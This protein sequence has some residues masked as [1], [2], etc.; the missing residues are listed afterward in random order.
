[1]RKY[2]LL[3]VLL[4]SCAFIITNCT[5]EGPEGPPGPAGAQG[6][7]GPPGP[8]GPAGAV[9]SANVIYSNW[10]SAASQGGFRDTTW[11]A[12]QGRTFHKVVTGLT[13]AMLDGGVVLSYW[14]PAGNPSSVIQLAW[15]HESGTGEVFHQSVLG[16]I[17]YL[18]IGYG[19]N[20][21]PSFSDSNEFRYILIPGSV[22]GG[23]QR[24]PSAMSYAEVCQ[25]YGIPQ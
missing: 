18:V 24:D 6:N 22:L 10:F 17:H 12:S 1:M 19:T 2:F 25:A 11:F 5:K 4:T 23:R 16:K 9:G 8:T 7:P 15:T 13:Q 20:A 3:S 21:P 14:R